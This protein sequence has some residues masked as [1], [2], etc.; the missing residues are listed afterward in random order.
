MVYLHVD[1]FALAES[2]RIPHK[3]LLLGLD[4][5][6]VMLHRV[7]AANTGASRSA[8]PVVGKALAVELEAL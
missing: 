5:L 3:D 4:A 6:S 1:N 8:E 2:V 7:V